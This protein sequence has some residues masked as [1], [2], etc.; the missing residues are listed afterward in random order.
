[1]ARYRHRLV[2]PVLM[3]ALVA[4][5]AGCTSV[6][7]RASPSSPSSPSVSPESSAP[8]DSGDTGDDGRPDT[9]DPAGRPADLPPAGSSEQ[10]I[11]VDGYERTF[12]LYR[13]G[14]LAEDTPAPL[15]VML[16]GVLGTGQQA[17]SWYGWNAVADREGFVVAYPDARNR[18]WAVTD[19]CCGASARDGIDDAGFVLAV[20]ESLR[21][22]MTLDPDRLYLSGI[23]NG[24]ML[25]Y[26]L[27]CESS[28]F[29]AVAVVATTMLTD[30]SAAVPISVL[31][32][33]GTADDT[34]PYTGGTGRREGASRGRVPDTVDGP[35]V[36]DLVR[37]WQRI[38]DCAPAQTRTEATVTTSTASCPGGR[39]VT[40]ITIDG[41][42]HQWPGSSPGAASRLLG[43]DPPATE[44]DATT[45]SWNFLAAH[46]KPA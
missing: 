40:L 32:I 1:M 24:G 15:L 33:H 37:R 20:V 16:H 14:G 26:K 42:G 36:P 2:A 25:A 30:C 5:I 43:L 4:L 27:V 38:D 8:D 3:G 41:A 17:E 18:A 22:R 12:R 21:Q 9:G 13:P 23:S 31:H 35:P 28:V 11:T 29:A 6:P 44:I 45:T 7:D 46:A 39:D 10:T 34:I 19:E